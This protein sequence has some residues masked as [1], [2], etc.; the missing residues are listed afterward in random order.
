MKLITNNPMVRDF[1]VGQDD[2]ELEYLDVLGYMDVLKRARD[3]I[4]LGQVLL[5]HP[6]SGSV[7]PNETPYKS[8]AIGKDSLHDIDSLWLIEQ[9]IAT[10]IKFEKNKAMPQWTEQ[11]REDFMV[12]DFDLIKNALRR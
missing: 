12:V 4:H 8:V 6:L 11:V 10:Y 2:I 5:T 7:K 3:E 9:A 1:F